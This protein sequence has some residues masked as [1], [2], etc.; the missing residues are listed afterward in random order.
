M[1]REDMQALAKHAEVTLFGFEGV[2]TSS[3][4]FLETRK[5]AKE[6]TADTWQ[7]WLYLTRARGL[8]FSLLTFL[9][10]RK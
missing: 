1:V 9:F 2:E 4:R 8:K 7:A 10:T 5:A 6:R 3:K